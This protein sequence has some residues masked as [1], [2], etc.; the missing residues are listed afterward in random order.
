MKPDYRKFCNEHLSERND[1]IMDVR[2]IALKYQAAQT[3]REAF[4]VDGEVAA[5]KSP[6][7]ERLKEFYGADECRCIQ[8][9][10]ADNWDV[11]GVSVTIQYTSLWAFKNLDYFGRNILVENFKFA[12]Y[13]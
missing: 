13:L 6:Y 3:I 2:E 1:F 10:D 7:L 5:L 12:R 4:K 11:I 9:L 8:L